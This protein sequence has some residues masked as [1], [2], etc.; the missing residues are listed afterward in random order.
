MEE[1]GGYYLGEQIGSGGMGRV[2]RAL[3]ADGRNVAVKILHPAISADPKARARLAREV[4]TLHRVR[5]AGVARVLDAEVDDTE[6]FVVTELIDGPTL[7]DDVENWGAFT[8]D[9]LAGLASGLKRALEQIHAA[10]V[11]HRDLKPSNVMM[12]STGPVLIDFGIAQ[13]AD[14]ARFTATGLVTGT[15]GYL[16]PEALLGKDPSPAGDWWSWA[17]VLCFAGT[18][19]APYGSGPTPGI[20]ARVHSEEVDTAGLPEAVADVLRR[21]LAVSPLDRPSPATVLATIYA[22]AE[23]GDDGSIAEA[24]NT[25]Q[26]LVTEHLAAAREQLAAGDNGADPRFAPGAAGAAGAAS[27]AGAAGTAAGAGIIPPPPPSVGASPGGL[28]GPSPM[29]GAA[30]AVTQQV[31]AL[32]SDRDSGEAGRADGFGGSGV[33]G[34]ATEQLGVHE[35]YGAVGERGGAGPQRESIFAANSEPATQVLPAGGGRDATRAYPAAP[36]YG[37]ELD[38]LGPA[39]VGPPGPA[40]VDGQLPMGPRPL[41]APHPWT[42]IAALIGLSGLSLRWPGWVLVG[43]LIWMFITGIVGQGMRA[44]AYSVWRYGRRASDGVMIAGR[45]LWHTVAH[46]FAA[47]WHVVIAVIILSIAYLLGTSSIADVGSGWASAGTDPVASA[48]SMAVVMTALWWQPSYA[49]G[50]E[51]TRRAISL[52]FPGFYW[53]ALLALALI[54][55]AGILLM[56]TLG[57]P[58]TAN[59]APL[60]SIDSWLQQRLFG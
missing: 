10:G 4:A 47:L 2:Y 59:W 21:A 9:E 32:G 56:V 52:A 43:V 36:G 29:T 18:G 14:D 49:A 24:E 41:S 31:P 17:A 30:D 19:R 58:A 48:I 23:A 38:S 12:D 40:A 34:G 45:A 6:A 57:T 7:Q 26:V 28:G 1:F 51:A 15:A 42:S 46:A 44:H 22:A 5:G 35:G 3:D 25:R 37:G 16:D 50:R 13:V 27:A 20:I 54:G 55:L 39:E 33:A 53:R 8:M 11:V 60:S